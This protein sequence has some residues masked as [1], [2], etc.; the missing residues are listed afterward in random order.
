MSTLNKKCLPNVPKSSSSQVQKTEFAKVNKNQAT[1]ISSST[2]AQKLYL[3]I[4]EDPKNNLVFLAV[5]SVR[6]GNKRGA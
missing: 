3:Q 5:F 1:L 6:L 4:G 2:V